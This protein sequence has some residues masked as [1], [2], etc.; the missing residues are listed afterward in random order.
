M[1]NDILKPEYTEEQ[2]REFDRLRNLP[3]EKKLEMSHEII[4]EA[5]SKF[6]RY[7]VAFSGGKDSLVVLHLLRQYKPDILTV[8]V[9]TRVEMPETIKYIKQLIKDW[10]LNFVELRGKYT[11]WDIVRKYGLP[12]T[13]FLSEHR[14]QLAKKGLAKYEGAPKCCWYLKEEPAIKFFHKKHIQCV[15]F[16]IT[17]DESYNRKWAIIRKGTLFYHTSHRHYKCY[18]IAYWSTLDVWRYIEEN[19]LP[20]NP[21]YD[22]VDRVGCITCTAYIGWEKDMAKLYP[23]LYR[24]ICSMLGVNLI[25]DYIDDEDDKKSKNT[26]QL[27]LE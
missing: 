18:P 11:F 25:T 2:L 15:F 24:K 22:K 10:N 17:W 14:I 9:N 19:N 5:L 21:A 13:R 26:G 8:F 12:A 27:K 20:V 23:G 4:Q 7:A 1:E 6:Q 3:Y 16:G